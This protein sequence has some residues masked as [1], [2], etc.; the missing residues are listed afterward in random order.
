MHYRIGQVITFILLAIACAAFFVSIFF[1]WQ[2]G[3]LNVNNAVA[4]KGVCPQVTYF[5]FWQKT[6][7]CDNDAGCSLPTYPCA[8]GAVSS[9]DWRNGCISGTDPFQQGSNYCKNQYYISQTTFGLTI[10]SA[11]LLALALV[12]YLLHVL[13]CWTSSWALSTTSCGMFVALCVLLIYSIGITMAISADTSAQNK[14]CTGS[15]S[16]LFG[17]QD[18]PGA[19]YSW[20]ASIGWIIN[21]CAAIFLL[22]VLFVFGCIGRGGDQWVKAPT[23]VL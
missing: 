23:H 20:G 12:A 16:T 13:S 8:S 10:C 5:Y 3:I 2:Y 22:I 4:S 1:P 7:Q 14:P 21:L 15:C 9:S 19:S 18:L 11:I 17:S 6:F